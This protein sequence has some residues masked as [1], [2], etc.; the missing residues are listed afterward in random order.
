MC[1]IG[2]WNHCLDKGGVIGTVL[3]DLSQAFDSLDHDLLLA[4]LSAYEVDSKS[5]KLLQCYLSNRLQR[6]Q[7]QSEFSE[8]LEIIPGAPQGSILGP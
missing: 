3:I 5:L 7:I 8:W 4:K 2:H 1:I 6:T